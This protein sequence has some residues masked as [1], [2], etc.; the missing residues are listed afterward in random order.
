MHFVATLRWLSR[1]ERIFRGFSSRLSTQL[2]AFRRL[3]F[4]SLLFAADVALFATNFPKPR[5]S[6]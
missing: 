1:S 3:P 5:L 4:T 6:V 2:F